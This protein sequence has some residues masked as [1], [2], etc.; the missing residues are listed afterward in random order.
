[1]DPVFQRSCL[2]VENNSLGGRTVYP[3]AKSVL[4]IFYDQVIRPIE[5]GIVAGVADFALGCSTAV[6]LSLLGVD[7]VRHR[8]VFSG[9]N[10]GL[11]NLAWKPWIENCIAPIGEELIFRVIV[12]GS[13]KCFAAKIIPDPEKEVDILGYVKLSRAALVAVIVTA[14]FF[15]AMHYPFGASVI[16]VVVCCVS[17]LLFGVLRERTGVASSCVAHMVT[18]ALLDMG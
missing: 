17:G 11:S 3:Q 16:Q 6:V 2:A 5:I 18:N 12:Q 1:M 9:V 15:G 10:L 14:V 7:H 4:Q 13:V 8:A